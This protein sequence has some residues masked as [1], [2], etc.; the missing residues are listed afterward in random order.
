MI[1]E[2][3]LFH[4]K[5][6]DLKA[7]IESIAA[8]GKALSDKVSVLIVNAAGDKI[9]D[10]IL[11]GA[12]YKT[13][14][15]KQDLTSFGGQYKA[16]LGKLRQMEADY[17]HFVEAGDVLSKDAL[18]KIAEKMD[19]QSVEKSQKKQPVIVMKLP[20]N[21][22]KV[23]TKR[24][25][26]E[27]NIT[28]C[29]Y[30]VPLAL[31]QMVIPFGLLQDISLDEGLQFYG[32]YQLLNAVFEKEQELALTQGGTVT[33]REDNIR[34]E[35]LFLD[36]S[37]R[38]WYDEFFDCY[39]KRLIQGK[40]E[41]KGEGVKKEE[42]LDLHIQYQL[43]F[44]LCRMFHHNINS[45]NKAVYQD[46]YQ[47]L[48]DAVAELLCYIQDEIIVNVNDYYPYRID[49]MCVVYFLK[50]K[51]GGEQCFHYAIDG[52]KS[53]VYLALGEILLIN[54]LG[55][56][57]RIEKIDSD[58]RE[59]RLECT[60]RVFTT[61]ETF[62]LKAKMNKKELKVEEIY[63]YSHLKFFG[64]TIERKHVYC[65]HV[66]KEALKS[67]AALA[68]MWEFMGYEQ[69]AEISTR[70]FTSRLNSE[71]E[72]AY[73]ICDDVMID[74][75]PDKKRM[76]FTPYTRKRHRACEKRYLND[77]KSI[78]RDL[79]ELRKAYWRNYP[80]Y[81][82]KK[83]WITFDKL[84]KGGD[85]GE[86]FYKYART[87]KDGIQVEYLIKEESPDAKRL[88]KEGYQPLYFGTMEHKLKFL[89]ADVIAATHPNVPVY[90]A[91]EPEE[92]EYMK[93]LFHGRVVCIQHG[94]AVQKLALNLYQT[95]DNISTFYVASKY[96]KKNLLHP[97]Y[98]YQEEQIELTGI[99]R[100]DGLHNQDQRQILIAPTWRSYIA[101]PP[102][103]G[104]TRP[105]SPTFK[106]TAYYQIFQSLINHKKLIDAA[107]RLG[108]RIVYLVH[109]TI[110][111]QL[112]DF[113]AE[114]VVTIQSPVGA[115]Y[116]KLLTES[117]LMVTDYSGIQF[118]FAYMRK[119]IVYYHPDALP[120]HY[121]EGG[122][123]YDTMGF[124]E[125]E[126]EEDDLVNLLVGYMENQCR[127]KEFYQNRAD[128]FFGFADDKSSERI[129]E[130][131]LVKER[132]R[133]KVK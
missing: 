2:V 126:K 32:E 59:I 118:D 111:S 20:P 6:A 34:N 80:K 29:P 41:E 24:D 121:G 87:R 15:L 117:S 112:Q 96:E 50:L 40:E 93:D 113:T 51:Y 14:E 26:N 37:K 83:I 17:V 44:I 101:M 131:L 106:E 62:R 35:I 82:R 107:K 66:P 74:L 16:I 127:M 48:E 69:V 38:E 43:F 90:S 18:S 8:S 33:D 10:D 86:Y 75:R 67:R 54:V 76:F 61:K 108:Y 71:V 114:D 3:I 47:M 45:R 77:L 12:S 13:E 104:S 105:Y 78:S 70:R 89:Y 22:S 19:S 65:V 36:S 100:F 60:T 102:S 42:I 94:L 124:G 11:S 57:V 53:N 122:F 52:H 95:Y 1:T 116:E 109:P 55:E 7:T 21:G 120:P 130:S 9:S 72:S 91:L 64:K 92:F 132:E 103:V 49:M 31:N 73:C 25:E 110:A 115:S 4:N 97:I 79:Y 63:R 133:H 39:V 28:Q 30:D 68:L 23:R 5:Y 81:H 27:L 125:I 46:D 84:Y 98:G 85:C 128:D 99:P 129:Y 88:V 123:I 119:P 58:E 56:G